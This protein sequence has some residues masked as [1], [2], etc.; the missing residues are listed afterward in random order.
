MSKKLTNAVQLFIHQNISIIIINAINKLICFFNVC[1][2]VFINI[3]SIIIS[4]SIFGI[5]RFDHEFLFKRF[6]Q[7]AVYMNFININDE[8]LKII[9]HFLNDEK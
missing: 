8:F 4:I 3:E 7:R 1:E 2:V 9:L 5:K 6:F